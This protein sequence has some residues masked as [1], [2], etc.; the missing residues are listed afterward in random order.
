MSA[1]EAE[2]A[3]GRLRALVHA[4]SPSGDRERIRVALD[5]LADWGSG[6][7]G[8]RGRLVTL[9]GVDHLLWEATREPAVLLLGHVDTVWPAGTAEDWPFALDG[10]VARGPGIF[11]MKA[12]LVAA[13]GA[14]ERVD[15]PGRIA[16]LVTSDEE[17][18]STTSRGLIESVAGGAGAVLVIEPS[19]DGALKTARCGAGLYRLVFDGVEAHAGLDAD[20]GASALV[21]LAHHVLSL[22]QVADPARGTLVTPTR[23][24][25]GTTVNTVA[26]RAELNVDVRARSLRELRRVDRYLAALEPVDRRVTV[27]VEGGV[28]RP[29]LEEHQSRELFAL[30]AGVAAAEGLGPLTAAAVGGAS[31]GNFTAALGIPTLDGLGPLGGGAHARSEWVSLASVL[32]RSVLIAGIVDAIAAGRAGRELTT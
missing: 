13:L 23:A 17:V 25:A 9:D 32:E 7:F 11:D 10:D 22:A 8:R 5:L 2:R 31:D 6:A 29:P 4:E 24:T 20:Q 18:G 19:L 3:A 27:T 28:N 16:M 21:E 12:G 26:G 1:A 14:V 15:D 30:A